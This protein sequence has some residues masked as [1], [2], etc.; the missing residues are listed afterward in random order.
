MSLV[1]SLDIGK[2]A[3]MV[4]TQALKVIGDNISNVSTPGYSRKRLEL[5]NT[6]HSQGNNIS[7]LEV[8]RIRDQFIDKHIRKENQSLGS[9][10][11]KSQLYGQIE[12]VFLE[13]S[14]SGLKSLLGEFWN[15][16]EDLA[17]NPENITS[18]GMVVQRANALSQNLNRIDYQLNETRKTADSYIAERLEQLNDKAKQIA[19][20]NS[21][22]QFIEA[23]GQ[24]ASSLRDHRD[25]L[26]DQV[27]KLIYIKTIERDNGSVTM[28][29]GGRA[30]VED[31]KFNP[32]KTF[33]TSI[34][35][36]IVNNLKWADD[37]GKV[38]I[39]GG[40]IAGLMEI[41][42]ETIP[43]FLNKINRLA[44]TIINSVNELH[45][46]GYGLDGSTGL[47][48][49]EGTNAKNIKVNNDPING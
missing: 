15:S 22:I 5:K 17:N 35:G 12:S 13:P 34:D 29:I 48:F 21:Q 25:Q 45:K 7:L 14:E 38:D 43:D 49:F 11:M 28:Y 19:Y 20:L 46:T 24:E 18:R 2:R 23:S 9:W 26:I 32:L 41:R 40:E 30:I 1:G 42:D 33:K 39:E 16:W 36:M 44:K 47:N 6:I 31:A 3:M 10:E 27:S 37:D 4:Q 8:R